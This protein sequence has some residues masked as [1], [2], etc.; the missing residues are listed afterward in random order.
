MHYDH[1]VEDGVSGEKLAGPPP[2]RPETDD[3]SSQAPSS[4]QLVGGQFPPPAALG[5][6][7]AGPAQADDPGNDHGGTEREQRPAESFHRLR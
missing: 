7:A 5:R 3:Q 6:G 4:V 1:F 2:D